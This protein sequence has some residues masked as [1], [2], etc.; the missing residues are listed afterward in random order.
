MDIFLSNFQKFK[1][2]FFLFRKIWHKKNYEKLRNFYFYA[3]FYVENKILLL[4]YRCQK[5]TNPQSVYNG[6]MSTSEIFL[7]SSVAI[8]V[9]GFS[10]NF[11]VKT[12]RILVKTLG[13]LIFLISVFIGMKASNDLI[14]YLDNN[15]GK[16]FLIM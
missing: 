2:L 12:V 14:H 8:A 3:G 16:K 4:L 7:S 9:I 10:N 15:K 5:R 11:K 1:I 6:T 13:A